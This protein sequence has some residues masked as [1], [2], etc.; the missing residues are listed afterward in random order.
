[1]LLYQGMLL[2]VRRLRVDKDLVKD[3]TTGQLIP[4]IRR[5]K[6]VACLVSGMKD[7]VLKYWHLVQAK[8]L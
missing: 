6:L 2:D 1:M 8:Y 7:Q 5:C 4:D 3:L